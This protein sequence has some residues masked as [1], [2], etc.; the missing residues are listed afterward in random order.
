MK[1]KAYYLFLLSLIFLSACNSSSDNGSNTPDSNDLIKENSGDQQNDI[2]EIKKLIRD[3]YVWKNNGDRDPVGIGMVTDISDTKYTAYRGNEFDKA[4]KNIKKS[5]FFTEKFLENFV[6]IHRLIEQK[7]GNGELEWL[8]GEMPDFG[9]GADPW[10]NC[11]D[12]PFDKPNP[13]SV[14][15]IEMINLSS[16]KGEFYWKWGNMEVDSGSGWNN[17]KYHFT[18]EKV[19]DQWKIDSLEGINSVEMTE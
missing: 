11:Q 7:M 4:V 16:N 5:N 8:V 1:L 14:I 2:M 9:T 6:E 3:V 17:F 12:V 18:V 19:G 13:W 10:C 15:D